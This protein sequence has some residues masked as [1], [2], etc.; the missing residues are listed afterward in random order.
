[1]PQIET[2]RLIIRPFSSDEWKS[3]QEL[4]VNKMSPKKNPHEPTPPPV[5]HPQPRWAMRV[6]E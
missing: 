5:V 3:I 1:M 4:T 6:V 2:T